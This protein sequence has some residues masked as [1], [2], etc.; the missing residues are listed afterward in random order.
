MSDNVLLYSD[1]YMPLATLFVYLLI[2]KQVQKQESVLFLYLLI[3]TILFAFTNILAENGIHNMFLYHAYSLIEIVLIS[4]YLFKLITKKEFS[5]GFYIVVGCYTLFFIVNI[6]LLEPLSIFNSNSAGI[7]NLIL[8]IL[9]MYYML[10][11]SKSDEI[12]HFQ[13]LPSFWIVSGFLIYNAISILV[14]ISYKY[15]TSV[16]LPEEGNKLWFLLTFAIII[17]F[18]L[19]SIGLLCYKRRP[20]IQHPFL[21]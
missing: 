20:T 4:F 2:K 3:S 21:L 10:H 8:M 6:L 16:K 18:V 12:L 7:S 11:L 1:T 5:K 17:K 13:K 19:I 14:V 15:F 9:C